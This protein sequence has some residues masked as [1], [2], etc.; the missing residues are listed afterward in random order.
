[1][2]RSTPSGGLRRFLASG[3]ALATVA[4]GSVLLGTPTPAFAGKVLYEDAFASASAKGDWSVGG[5]A[6]WKPCLTAGGAATTGSVP[7][8]GGASETDGALRLTDTAQDRSAYA[9]YQD[10]LKS[11]SGTDI[12]FDMYMYNPTVATAAGNRPIS[13]DGISF[14]LI[15]GAKNVT[16]AG[17]D[18]GRLGYSKLEGAIV[19]I[20]FDEFGNFSNS[21]YFPKDKP[22]RPNQPNHIVV[23]GDEAGGYRY[24]TSDPA[25]ENGKGVH[26]LADADATS[27]GKAA[28]H[29][30]IRL[31]DE[32]VLTVD[33][34]YDQ[35]QPTARTVREIDRFD[36]A[37]I[38]GQDALPPT[39][40]FG[41][42]AATGTFTDYHEIKNLR[43]SS[44]ST[45]LV[46]D[47]LQPAS[48]TD[49]VKEPA[50]AGG[51]GTKPADTTAEHTAHETGDG[52]APAVK[53]EPAVNTAAAPAA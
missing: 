18:G 5:S 42:G 15:D 9:V 10:P 4:A 40:K 50:T 26:R 24:L 17:E 23:R 1:M 52:T 25:G 33:V 22:A 32:N 39:F 14:F 53:E 11:G 20:G 27:R 30:R 3:A 21:A 43:I 28:R 35:G 51:T 36:L 13:A 37:N 45:D 44:L 7:A 6:G 41:F 46:S 2:T 8:C 34:T 12:E 19:G 48:V 49:V 38:P 29:V 31:S 16:K 47:V